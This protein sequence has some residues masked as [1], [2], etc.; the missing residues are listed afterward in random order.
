[1][2]TVLFLYAKFVKLCG[3]QAPNFLA[4]FLFTGYNISN[5][6]TQYVS[7]S[8]YKLL[9]GATYCGT[10]LGKTVGKGMYDA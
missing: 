2:R 4:F 3:G 9:S 8:Y 10:G 5:H 1:M 7:K 6:I